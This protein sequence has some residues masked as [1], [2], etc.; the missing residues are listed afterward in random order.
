[1]KKS[2]GVIGGDRR[3]AE[4]ARLLSDEGNHV[5]TYGLSQWRPEGEDGLPSAADAKVIVLPLPLVKGPGLLNCAEETLSLAE[6]FSYFHKEQIIFAGKVT[7]E[8]KAEAKARGL[9]LLD[10]L[11]REELAV[12]NAIPTAEGA[13]Q[14]AMEQLPVTLCGT[15][16]LV[17]GYGR[18]GKQLVQRLCALGAKV[19][20]AVRKPEDRVWTELFFGCPTLRTDRLD[21]RLG[22]FQVLFNT[23]PALLL[24]RGLLEQLRPD[25]LCID[26][27]S[28]PGLD[29][30]AAEDLG[31][32]L[33]L[34]R[35]LPGKVA[36]VTAAKAIQDTITHILEERGG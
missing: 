25:C 23:A 27:A 14:I 19:S 24:D 17:L 6:L 12:A 7:A 20:V 13:I 16:V 15:E 30:G 35:G 10:Y 4:L 31:L 29:A 33:V 2:F 18:I 3:Q 26:L 8:A 11:E 5:C 28:C 36:P 32:S 9:Q 22:R 1:M 34:A 21:G